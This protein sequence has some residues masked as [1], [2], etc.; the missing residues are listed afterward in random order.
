MNINALTVDQLA[1][2]LTAAGHATV[3]A[4][5]VRADIQA[6]APTAKGRPVRIS[7]V[8]YTAWLAHRLKHGGHQPP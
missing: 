3:T 1:K 7:L 5:K 8:H 4:A 6:G 2:L